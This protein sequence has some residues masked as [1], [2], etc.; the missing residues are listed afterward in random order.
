MRATSRKITHQKKRRTQMEKKPL[1]R[2]IKEAEATRAL[3]WHDFIP[4]HGQR[5]AHSHR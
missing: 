3:H 1:M 4:F 5:K 2:A